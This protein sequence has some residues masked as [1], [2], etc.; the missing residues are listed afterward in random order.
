MD[1]ITF[2]YAQI[3]GIYITITSLAALI[4]PN[5][6]KKLWQEAK[7]SRALIFF[8]G[9]LATLLGSILILTH[10]NWNGLGASVVSTVSWIIFIAGVMELVLPHKTLI[11]FY[12]KLIAKKYVMT[13]IGLVT[14]AAGVYMVLFGFNIIK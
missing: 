1:F 9:A 5:K 10:K 2:F 13:V 14:L 12:D 4:N 7:V 6:A 8:D 3:L 11:T